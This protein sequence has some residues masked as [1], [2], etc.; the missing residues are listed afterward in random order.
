MKTKFTH[1]GK[2]V[3]YEFK[4]EDNYYSVYLHNTE[5]I[6]TELVRVDSEDKAKKLIK[7]LR[8]VLKENG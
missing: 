4:A 1:E 5:S 2:K 6:R 3:S 7:T 8:E